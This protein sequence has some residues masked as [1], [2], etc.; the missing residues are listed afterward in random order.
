MGICLATFYKWQAKYSGMDV[1]M[2]S[3]IKALEL[4]NARLKKDVCRRAIEII[5]IARSQHK[6]VVK[7]SQRRKIVVKVVTDKS[8]SICLAC[9][10]SLHWREWLSLSAIIECRKLM[11]Q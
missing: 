9:A 10:T 3:R 1:Y 4:E 8:V 7:P 6:K 5:D 11:Y 2:M